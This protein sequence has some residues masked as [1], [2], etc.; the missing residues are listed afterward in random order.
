[1]TGP[2]NKS[3]KDV[4]V[5]EEPTDRSYVEPLPITNISSATSQENGKRFDDGTLNRYREVTR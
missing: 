5:K 4:A 1:M 3:T 2:T